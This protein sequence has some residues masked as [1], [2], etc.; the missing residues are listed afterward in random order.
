MTADVRRVCLELHPDD[1]LAAGREGIELKAHAPVVGLLLG[2]LGLD[3][4]DGR[5]LEPALVE[6][7]RGL[8]E[9]S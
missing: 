7:E 6:H 4:V 3:G 9:R 5:L 2:G 1:E 8:L